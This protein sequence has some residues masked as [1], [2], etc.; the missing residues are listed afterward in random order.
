MTDASQIL[1]VEDDVDLAEMLDTLFQDLGYEVSTTHYGEE[2][3]VLCEERMPEVVILDIYLPDIDGY[4]VC[5]RLRN[6][7]LTKHIAVILLTQRTLKGDKLLGLE[8][9]AVDYI[10]K[11]FDTEE[12]KLRVK[13]TI[14]GI[15]HKRSMDGVTG[16][17][18]SRLIEEQFR[19]LLRRENW[20]LMYIGISGFGPFKEAY[21]LE[22]AKTLLRITASTLL[23]AVG[24]LGTEDD[25][26]GHVGEDD[27]VVITVPARAQALMDRIKVDFKSALKDLG[28]VI[29]QERARAI[30]KRKQQGIIP[31]LDLFIGLLTSKERAFT[32]IRELAEAAAKAR[33]RAEKELLRK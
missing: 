31:P 2:A 30:K 21:G 22:S 10:T 3:L 13:N 12:L 16:L 18:R 33:R 9:G 14:R 23:E 28:T 26:V 29:E 8:L 27:F 20:A 25:F 4:E 24:E 19:L 15:Q 11:P 17:P 6:N 1:I 5:R 32:D 7:P